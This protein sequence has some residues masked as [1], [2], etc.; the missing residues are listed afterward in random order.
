[1]RSALAPRRTGLAAGVLALG[2]ALTGCGA[3]FQAQTYQER[4]T[5]DGTNTAVGAIGLRNVHV[6]PPAEGG[7]LVAAGEDALVGFVI[8]NDGPEDDRLVEITSPDARS[9]QLV[10]GD[11]LVPTEAVALP[12]LTTTGTRYGAVLQGLA[13]D[14]RTGRYVELVFRFERNG[15]VTVQV[16]LATT[17]ENDQDE[18]ERSENFHPIGE[19]AHGEGGEE[20]ATGTGLSEASDETQDEQ[21]GEH[22]E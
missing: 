3:N 2:L 8:V 22:S 4:P 18:R 19:G 9:V 17:G 10:G 13:E 15:E 14:L 21:A 5:S 20:P 7:D 1:V 6:L 12:R 16:P 11:A